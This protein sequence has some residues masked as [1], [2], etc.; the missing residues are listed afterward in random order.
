[1]STVWNENKFYF[2]HKKPHSDFLIVSR[3]RERKKKR[4][5]SY[6]QRMVVVLVK[7]VSLTGHGVEVKTCRI[8]LVYLNLISFRG[9]QF[10]DIGR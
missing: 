8:W 6:L 9:D 7:N 2:N 4:R 1:M 3:V 5:K 10:I